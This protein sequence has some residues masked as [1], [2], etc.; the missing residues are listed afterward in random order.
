[1]R[2][3]L[4]ALLRH[5]PESHWQQQLQQQALTL[6]QASH[7]FCGLV[8]VSA[9]DATDVIAPEQ[10]KAF[11][12]AQ[13]DTVVVDVR[14]PH[15]QSAG[16]LAGYLPQQWPVL[17]VPLSKL[18]DALIKQQLNVGQTLLLV[19]RSGNRSLMACKVLGRMGFNK[20]YNLKGG[21]ALLR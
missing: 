18:A 2:D 15:E 8:E 10:L 5:E 9:S 19:C 7:Y 17:E 16:A 14:E 6:R 21:T 4:K 11:L 13:S 3:Y 20:V 12:T 1:M